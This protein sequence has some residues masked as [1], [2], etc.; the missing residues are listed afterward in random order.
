MVHS[1]YGLDNFPNEHL[2]SIAKA[3]M[4]A[5]IVY[6]GHPD[7]HLH[8]FPDP[9]ALWPGTGRGYCDFANLAWRAE[10]YGLD[11]YV[12]SQMVCDRA[13][14]A[15]DAYD[16]YDASFGRIFR[17]APALRGLILVGESFEFPSKDPH[18]SGNRVQLKAKDD[19]RPSSGRYPSCDY[20]EMLSLVRDVVRRYTPDADIV[21]WSYNFGWTPK[22]A[23]LSLIER[24]PRDITYL[25][26]F[27]VWGKH[28]DE[29][30]RRF[31]IADYSIS[32]PGPSHIFVEEAEKAHECGLRLYTM[33]NTGGRTWDS[34]GA[35]YIPAPDCWMARYAAMRE[36]KE[37]YGLCGLM[38]NHHY[39]WMPSFLSLLAKNAFFTNRLADEDI[40]AAIARRDFGRAAGTALS[41]WR[42]ISRG[43]E[44]VIPAMIDQYG[45]YRAGPT[46]PLLFTQAAAELK[47]PKTLWA[48]HPAGGI[49]KPVYPDEVF[50]D[51]DNSLLRLE[52]V[53]EAAD[54]FGEGLSLLE[55]AIK[56]GDVEYGSEPSRGVAVVRYLHAS[57]KT[58]RHVMRWN[59]AKKLLFALRE[60]RE[61]PRRDELFSAIGLKEQTPAALAA[62]LRADA[63]AERECVSEGL[64]AYRED[65]AIGFEASMEY[66]F[67]EEMAAWKLGELDRSLSLLDDY[68][69]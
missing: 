64:A 53:S 33:G 69:K 14:D 60:E 42:S 43:M 48:W 58:T 13:P 3:G 61:I 23:R 11:V 34:G 10:G 6:A 59:I 18:T 28:T 29:K 65:S 50:P 30:G 38:E 35:P 46:Y 5:I 19:R 32:V 56:E 67:N 55:D 40:L 25:V 2:L 41:G 45:P 39:G 22:E 52:R 8:G 27:E 1:G 66:V 26:T 51:V 47:I 7:S 4:D 15:P 54:L 12:Y 68:M 36:A 9:D 62:L 24:L 63:E 31:G 57:L 21:F 44:R 20:P 37:K 49:W 16:Y 17:E